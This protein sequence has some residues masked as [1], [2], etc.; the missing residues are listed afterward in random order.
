M[1]I[2]RGTKSHVTHSQPNL[3]Y[4]LNKV[5]QVLTSQDTNWCHFKQ[6]ELN[7]AVSPASRTCAFY[8]RYTSEM[9]CVMRVSSAHPYTCVFKWP[10][11]TTWIQPLRN[12]QTA[13]CFC[14]IQLGCPKRHCA[15]ADSR[16]DILLVGKSCPPWFYLNEVSRTWSV[17]GLLFIGGNRCRRPSFSN[18]LC[19]HSVNRSFHF[20]RCSKSVRTMWRT[21]PARGHSL[22]V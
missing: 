7:S 5:K 21:P 14:Y 6:T 19:Q 16:S 11:Q 12:E 4:L 17:C 1:L 15:T 18:L 13:D 20:W 9:I 8:V 2:T 10:D 22:Y 3:Y